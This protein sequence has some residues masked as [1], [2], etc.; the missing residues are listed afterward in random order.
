MRFIQKNLV[1]III[2]LAFLVGLSVF[3]YPT[4]ASYYNSFTQ[5]RVVA[6]YY[7]D[8][9]KLNVQDFSE[10]FAEARAYNEKLAKKSDR[11]NL[12]AADL[13]EYHSL[14]NFATGGVMGTLIIRSINVKLPVYHGTSEGVLQIGVG[15]LEGTSLPVGG[16][17]THAVLTGHRGLPSSI[18]LTNMDRMKVGDTFILHILNEILTYKVDQIIIVE[19]H[20]MDALAIDPDK[21]YCT[22]ITCTPYAI[23]SHRMLVRGHRIE[24]ERIEVSFEADKADSRAVALVIILPL[25]IVLTGWL[26]RKHRNIYGRKE[27]R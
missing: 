23:N 10:L 13:D 5:S 2:G 1:T 8:V 17:G 27:Q 20:E 16:I 21:D 11:F 24:N 3:L 14:L 26:F 12:T 4:V 15:H 18:L 25:L 19:P 9:G 6:R 22:L 7:E